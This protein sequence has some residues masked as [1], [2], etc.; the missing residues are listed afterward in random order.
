MEA[1][2]KLDHELLAVEAEHRVHAMLELVAPK[3]EAGGTRPPLNLAL[4]IDR[5]GSMQG[6]K[7][8][9][10]KECAAFLVR[11]LSP[12][13]NLALVTYDD[14]VELLRALGPVEQDLLHVI[15]QI[16]PGG[17]TNLSGGWLKGIEQV[18]T[19]DGDGLKKALLLTDGLANVGITDRDSLVGMAKRM[20]D[21]GAGTTTIGFGDDFDEELLTQ[22]ADAGRG[23]AYFAGTPDEAPG[24]FAQE[25]EGLMNLVAQ[26]VSV[27]IR[28]SDEVEVVAILNEYPAV[29]VKGGVQIQLGD[30]YSE[31]SR[32]VV[33]ELHIPELARLGMAKVAEIVVR[34][35]T[36]GDEI[37]THAVTLPLS[38]NM[39][40]ADEASEAEPNKDVIEEVTILKAAKAEEEARRKADHGDLDGA[41][42]A[43]DAAIDL[44]AAVPDNSERAGELQA[45]VERIK[46]VTD[47][48]GRGQWDAMMSKSSH[49][50]V[51]KSRRRRGGRGPSD[52][53]PASSR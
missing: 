52:G 33:F 37:A 47:E 29:P 36:V 9:V 12:R 34:Y 26:N 32:R 39:V 11:R 45:E 6:R 14:Q 31:E 46:G 2:I 43:F 41:R 25:F 50:N 51:Q 44:L 3:V 7:L 20:A 16:Y 1:R 17:T 42:V 27:E 38:V 24:I 49:Y 15:Q 48:V 19:S 4:V 18:Q 22:M 23:N 21:E 35:T 10:T 53:G 8:E 40:S 5:S 28:P 13:D 30:A